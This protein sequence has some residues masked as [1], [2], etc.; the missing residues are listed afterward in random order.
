MVLNIEPALST[1]TKRKF[2]S[3]ADA[4]DITGI[5]RWTW[6]RMAYDGRVSS[7]KVGSRLLIPAAE[8]DRIVQEGM[9]P[10]LTEAVGT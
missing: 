8:I 9:R 5:S 6:R 2:L 10:R 1:V 3:V 4:E 7:A